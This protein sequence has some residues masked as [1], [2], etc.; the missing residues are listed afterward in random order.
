MVSS[1]IL[2]QSSNLI[3]INSFIIGTVFIQLMCM[4]LYSQNF[5]WNSCTPQAY[6]MSGSP[7]CLWFN[8][9]N[10]TAWMKISCG[11]IV[12]IFCVT[13][14]FQIYLRFTECAYSMQCYIYVNMVFIPPNTVYMYWG[15]ADFILSFWLHTPVKCL[16]YTAYWKLLPSVEFWYGDS[17][18][19]F[20]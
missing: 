9:C 4:R 11:V 3:F 15:S 12:K 2:Y 10:G 1:F 13:Y 16:L 19:Q 6:F 18:D 14:I 7:S 5:A 17:Y 8:F 20:R